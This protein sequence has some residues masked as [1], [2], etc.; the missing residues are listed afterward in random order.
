MIKFERYINEDGKVAVLVS[1]G[2]GAGWSTWQSGDEEMFCMDKGLV[3]MRLRDATADEVEKYLRGR[4]A[5]YISTLGWGNVEIEWLDPGT[6][7]TITEYDGS[8]SLH[9]IADL[10]MTA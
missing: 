2:Y 3:E 7:F 10:S 6:Q 9:L 4:V 8:E 5:G 1:P